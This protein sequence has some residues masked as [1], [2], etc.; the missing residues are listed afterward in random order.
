MEH[1]PEKGRE[2]GKGERGRGRGERG[3]RE[4]GDEIRRGGGVGGV[5][6]ERA[7]TGVGQRREKATATERVSNEG[8]WGA[9]RFKL[10]NQSS[11]GQKNKN[12]IFIIFL[13]LYYSFFI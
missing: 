6:R 10:A 5:E 9:D 4:R 8:R 2:R 1:L 3:E 7:T 13:F 11:S 12:Y